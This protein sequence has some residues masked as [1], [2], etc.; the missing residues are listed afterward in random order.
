MKKTE[1]IENL[2]KE[3]DKGIYQ[4]EHIVNYLKIAKEEYSKAKDDAANKDLLR[5]MKTQNKYLSEI[6]DGCSYLTII[7]NPHTYHKRVLEQLPPELA[8]K[9]ELGKSKRNPLSTEELE[10]ISNAMVN[11]TADKPFIQKVYR[12]AQQ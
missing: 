3:L 7:I 9:V 6:F 4:S 1:I 11:L 2:G 8:Q 10:L 5:L 12:E